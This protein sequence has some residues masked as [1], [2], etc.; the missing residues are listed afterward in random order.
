MKMSY[1]KI[2]AEKLDMPKI[3][4]DTK[5]EL[6]EMCGL[7]RFQNFKM[8]ITDGEVDGKEKTG[9]AYFVIKDGIV[10]C[11]YPDWYFEEEKEEEE[12]PEEYFK[13]K[14]ADFTA[15]ESMARGVV[16]KS[17]WIRCKNKSQ[18]ELLIEKH[19][20]DT[21]NKD[22]YRYDTERIADYIKVFLER[23]CND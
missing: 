23:S 9:T 2:L 3:F 12:T 7:Q 10:F 19:L 14:K 15:L 1:Q 5:K 11:Y 6:D 4:V 20:V 17:E 21:E 18:R 16:A 13:R 22:F 8:D